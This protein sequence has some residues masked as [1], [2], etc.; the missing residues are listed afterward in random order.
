MPKSKYEENDNTKSYPSSG[1]Y[2]SV[3]HK[4]F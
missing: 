4:V 1:V 3:I 2:L